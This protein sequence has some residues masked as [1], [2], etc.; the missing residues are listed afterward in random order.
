MVAQRNI[1]GMKADAVIDAA[2]AQVRS[3]MRRVG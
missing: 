3:K 2:V 1:K